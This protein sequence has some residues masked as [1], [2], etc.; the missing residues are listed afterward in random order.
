MYV[1]ES[2]VGELNGPNIT[3]TDGVRSVLY[4]SALRDILIQV[5]VKNNLWDTGY[6]VSGTLYTQS[7]RAEES[8]NLL[9]LLSSRC[10]R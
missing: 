1:L 8:L 9:L 10:V 7:C 5:A 2:W 6:G 3:G 4:M